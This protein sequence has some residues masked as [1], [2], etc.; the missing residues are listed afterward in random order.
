MPVF[1][2]LTWTER[3]TASHE[4]EFGRLAVLRP[5]NQ[6]E[7][8]VAEKQVQPSKCK[9]QDFSIIALKADNALGLQ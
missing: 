2:P 8:E 5:H 9:R 6:D 4:L 1:G 3:I 7:P